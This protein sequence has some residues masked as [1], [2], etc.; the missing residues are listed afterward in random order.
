[1]TRIARY[2]MTRSCQTANLA[3][4]SILNYLGVIYALL[5]GYFLLDEMYSMLSQPGIVVIIGAVVLNVFFARGKELILK[6]AESPGQFP[7][8]LTYFPEIT[9][10]N[11]LVISITLNASFFKDAGASR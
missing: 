9:F 1:M 8:P 6:F 7:R 5:A 3:K 4:V 2:C 11:S 10:K